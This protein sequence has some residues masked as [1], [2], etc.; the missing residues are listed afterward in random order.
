MS[1][2]ARLLIFLRLCIIWRS[3]P[4]SKSV[5]PILPWKIVSPIKDCI[6]CQKQNGSRRMSRCFHHSDLCSCDHQ[7]CPSSI[8]FTFLNAL[9]VGNCCPISYSV[10]LSGISFALQYT[11]ISFHRSCRLPYPQEYDRNDHVS[12]ELLPDRSAFPPGWRSAFS[13]YLQDQ[14]ESLFPVP[15]LLQYNSL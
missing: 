10:R 5:L 9:T 7:A 2:M 8:V 1:S 3:F 6:L 11:G 15:V 14:R 13:D 4:P 12:E